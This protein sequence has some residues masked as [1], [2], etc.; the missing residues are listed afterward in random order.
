M[1]DSSTLV[2]LRRV[3]SLKG[4]VIFLG[5]VGRISNDEGCFRGDRLNNCE[6][7]K[8]QDKYKT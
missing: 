2:R 7:T 3:A 1:F 6:S 8:I 4:E 5:V